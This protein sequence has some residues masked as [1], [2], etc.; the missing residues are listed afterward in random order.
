MDT[1]KKFTHKYHPSPRL[2]ANQLADYLSA[3]PTARK[4]I[5][6][7]AK[8]PPTM[9]LIRYEDARAALKQ[10][11]TGK[12]DALVHALQ[13]LH[14]KSGGG[15]ILSDYAKTNCLLCI[16]AI[17]GFQ[18]A[19]KNMKAA[20]VVFS[21]PLLYTTRLKI[22]GVSVSV[23]VDLMTEKTDAKGQKSVGAA[24]LI[25]AKPAKKANDVADRCKSSA[26][27][28][29]ELLKSQIKPIAGLDPTLC[30]AIDVFNGTIYRAKSHQKILY[31]NV[32]NS[33]SEVATVWPTIEPPAN[34][35]GPP[36]PK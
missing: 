34:Y 28:I 33:C 14:H 29:H 19:E 16:D 36:I 15:S 13:A 7:D 25:F 3:G 17:E 5:L 9:L 2:S 35:N 31:K 32:E 23:S 24:M 11:L 21:L 4:T 8:F 26:M 27:L 1:A 20:G 10:H 30:M 6:R 18:A 12:A 22:S